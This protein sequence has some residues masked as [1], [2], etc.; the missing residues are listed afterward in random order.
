MALLSAALSFALF[1][2][3]FVLF[4][5][6]VRGR[7]LARVLRILVEPVL[8][9]VGALFQ[10]LMSLHALAVDIFQ[11]NNILLCRPWRERPIELI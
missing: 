7:W 1:S 3:S 10:S 5:R 6:A 9:C 11:L 4:K 8:E 2:F